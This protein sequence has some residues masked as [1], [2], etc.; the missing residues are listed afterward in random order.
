MLSFECNVIMREM[1]I[2]RCAD[3]FVLSIFNLIRK[4][5]L[6]EMCLDIHAHYVRRPPPSSSSSAAPG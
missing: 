4:V 3:C 1:H 6:D 2:Y 5:D